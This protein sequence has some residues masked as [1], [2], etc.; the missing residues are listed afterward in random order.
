MLKNDFWVKVQA[1][2]LSPILWR[3]VKDYPDKDGEKLGYFKT[4]A[5]MWRN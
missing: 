2:L 4:I 3:F 1:T 5:K